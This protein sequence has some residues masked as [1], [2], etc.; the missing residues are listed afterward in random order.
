MVV[1]PAGACEAR[2][3]RDCG[4]IQFG[5]LGASANLELSHDL[6]TTQ[7]Y[8]Q[9]IVDSTPLDVREAALCEGTNN[10]ARDE[11]CE[12]HNVSQLDVRGEYRLR[13]KR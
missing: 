7:I 2:C 10:A 6:P 5:Y 4:K 1:L 13:Q 12:K 11:C 9:H 8:E 3:A